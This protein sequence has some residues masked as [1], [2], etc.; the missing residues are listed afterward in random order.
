MSGSSDLTLLWSGLQAKMMSQIILV[1]EKHIQLDLTAPS[2]VKRSIVSA[3]A[4]RV[5]ALLENVWYISC[6]L[7]TSKK[8]LINPPVSDHQSQITS[9]R[10]PV[11]DPYFFFMAMDANSNLSFWSI[12]IL[13]QK[14][15]GIAVSACHMGH[16][17]GRSET[18][19]NKMVA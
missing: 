11:S 9:L 13:H 15:T 17:I 16:C 19:A 2:T 10:S 6:K 3:I 7:W 14:T 8:Y 18:A 4:L 1:R 12:L 5:A